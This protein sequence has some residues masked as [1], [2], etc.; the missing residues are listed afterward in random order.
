MTRRE[1]IITALA[2]VRVWIGVFFL[3]HLT[4]IT[5]PPLEPGSTWRQTDGYMVARNFYEQSANI[6]F[7]R[8][9]VAGE[10][11]GIVG[12]EFPILNYLVYLLSTLFGYHSW[13]GRLINLVVSSIGVY[14]LYKLIRE[15]F[16][17]KPAFNT[18][19]IVLSSLW[20]TYN[21]TN[22]PDTFAASLCLVSLYF[23]IKYLETERHR[24]FLIFVLLGAVGC[25][26]KISSAILLTVIAIPL[27]FGSARRGARLMVV[28]G[29]AC[30]LSVVSVWYFW[31]VPYLNT[32]Y[33]LE[34]HFFMGS[35]FAEGINLLLGD[36]GLTLKRF[37]DTPMKYVAFAVFVGSLLYA[38]AKKQ[39]LVVGVFLIPFT[40]YGV[41][42]LKLAIG[43]HTDAYYT[44]LFMLPMAFVAG[45]GIAQIERRTVVL[46]LLLAIGLEGVLNQ[47]H[48]FRIRQPYKSLE[49]LEEVMDG[50]SS[51]NDLIAISGIHEG[52]PTQMYMA[53]RR[54][55]SYPH[56]L[57]ENGSVQDSVRAK[58]CKYIVGV[59]SIFGDLHLSLRK[60]YDSE[61]FVV[62]SLQEP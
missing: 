17:E 29:A 30:I 18:A 57:L 49:G 52:D 35:T 33:G 48:V 3:L 47:V 34:G 21:R 37:Y 6:L 41:M 39:W 26:A 32:S 55:W 8:V 4:S 59:K 23:G 31:W 16:G 5:L 22:L 60:I 62:Y 51:R 1:R 13:F 42:I 20:F 40:F 54:G 9:D 36:A 7:P 15:H 24:Y 45:W 27:F 25:L 14:F 19:I 50:V 2:D 12:C 46:V 53:H 58:G 10:K 28:A 43:L 44:L 61:N 11:T 38:V 56:S